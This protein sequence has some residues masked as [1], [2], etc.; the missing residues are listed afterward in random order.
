MRQPPLVVLVAI[1]LAACSS[2]DQ[3]PGADLARDR[4]A[5]EARVEAGL[6]AAR[7]L[8]T[9][10]P[11]ADLARP[12]AAAATAWKELATTA[13]APL[14]AIWGSGAKSV[15]VVGTGGLIMRFDGTTWSTMT[16][17]STKDLHAVWGSGS[18]VL[19]AGDDTVLLYT[20]TAWEEDP[21]YWGWGGESFRALWGTGPSDVWAVGSGGMIQHKDATGWNEVTSGT[22]QDLTAIWGASATELFV[23][24]RAGTIL[25][26]DGKSFSKLASG[27]SSD[28]QA[29]WGS[30][31][32]DVWAA[33]LDGNLLHFDGTAWSKANL[34]GSQSY[35]FGLWG[36]GAKDVFLVGNGVF[37]PDEAAFH[38]DGTT[39]SKLSAPKLTQF[40]ALWGAGPT[41]VYA[42]AGTRILHY[43]GP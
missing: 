3:P 22:T 24:G 27:V 17:P 43:T 42:I 36:S 8:Q 25:K 31:A 10:R 30:S 28:L 14:R 4:G 37:K 1:S 2:N 29:L 20:G 38:F 5:G 11:T 34:G 15:F 32:T 21:D 23:V 13:S 16:S 35:F 41:D 6:D 19:A 12:D 33:G 40:G 18:T 7:D 26:G 9:D 39:W